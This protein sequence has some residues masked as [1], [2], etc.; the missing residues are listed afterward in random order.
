MLRRLIVPLSALAIAATAAA[1]GAQTA[2]EAVVVVNDQIVTR[3]DVEQR[4]RLLRVNGAPDS[5]ELGNIALQ[6]LIEDRLKRSAAQARGLSLPDE[7][8]DEAVAEYARRRE[9]TV[10]G[11]EARLQRA[12]VDRG[13]LESALASDLLW[14]DTI[15]GR[16]GPRATPTD[17]EIDQEIALA[18]AG[19]ASS[20]RLAEIALPFAARGEVGTRELAER[21]SRELNAGGSFPA[22]VRR[23]SASPSARNGGDLGWVPERALPPEVSGTIARLEPGQVSP[24]LPIQGGLALLKLLERRNE[25]APWAA[26]TT[27]TLLALT[28]PGESAGDLRARAAE[29][30]E[31][32]AD[33]AEIAEVAAALGLRAERSPPRDLD[34]LPAAQR[35]A[36][37]ALGVGQVSEVAAGPGGATA[38]VLCAREGGPGQ[39]ARD[40]LRDEIRQERLQRFA[41][42]YLEELRAEAV[43]EER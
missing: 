40:R 38:W 31:S 29:A 15:R 9:T 26:E 24:P 35:G 11:L 42:A 36:V 32:G 21:L 8:I 12:G 3:Y 10:A 2:F 30:A 28:A 34:A 16:F 5:P 14:R 17:A 39:E 4:A 7:A 20:Y 13:A 22:A 6:Q 43:I 37:A 33:C 19:Q 18:A 23:Y 41:A 25:A 1:A 27:V